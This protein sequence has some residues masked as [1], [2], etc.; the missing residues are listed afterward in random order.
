MGYYGVLIAGLW[1]QNV[2]ADVR[3]VSCTFYFTG[4]CS[5]PVGYVATGCIARASEG[6]EMGPP[7]VN[8]NTNINPTICNLSNVSNV[9]HSLTVSCAKVC[10]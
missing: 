3:V 10:N 9:Q 1:A 6:F 7:V 8:F 4:S 5:C 2:Q